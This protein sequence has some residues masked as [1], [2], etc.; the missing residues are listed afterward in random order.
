M[1]DPATAQL[2]RVV[3]RGLAA[4]K[5][6]EID[7]LGVFHPDA[8]NGVRF[9]AP[10]PRVFLAHVREDQSAAGRLYDDLAGA[11]FSPWMDARKLLP[12]QE[13][14]ARHRERHRDLG[15]LR[16]VL[17]H[18]LGDQAGR[19]PGG[20]PLRAWTA[21]NAFR[22]TRFSSYPC[23]WM[24][25]GCR[26]P[27]SASCST[28][29]CSRLGQGGRRLTAMMRREHALRNGVAGRRRRVS[30]QTGFGPASHV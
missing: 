9:E 3:I 13:L 23:A 24:R 6:V 10:P 27:Y 19:F 29:T 4:G 21:R 28:L 14:A 8:V 25:A 20:D 16:G 26:A 30:R 18:Q 22:S 12:G 17:F 1:T 2:A 11:G 15:L 5:A 7:G